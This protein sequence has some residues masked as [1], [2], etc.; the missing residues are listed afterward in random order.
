MGIHLNESVPVI[1][2]GKVME[3]LQEVMVY[4]H[5][6]RKDFEGELKKGDRIIIRGYG[7]PTVGTYTGA[8][9]SWETIDDTAIQLDITE[10]KYTAVKIDDVDKFQSDIEYMNRMSK[11]SAYKLA[12]LVDTTLAGLYGESSSAAVKTDATVDTA[13]IISDITAF[14]TAMAEANIPDSEMWCIVPFWAI[15]YLRMAGIRHADDLDDKAKN[16]FVGRVLGVDLYASNNVSGTKGSNEY[17]M[18][19]S[20]DAIALV[21]QIKE[22]DF[23]DK[24]EDTFGS[25]MRTLHVWGYKVVKP[26]ELFYADWT[27]NAETNI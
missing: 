6:A 12:Q 8:A 19:G 25:G 2:S 23:F 5:V 9:I 10:R 7:D 14:H 16:G 11:R 18:A 15:D 3:N 4:G 27:Y 17:P 22:S 24:F 13:T 20:Y 1:Y 26:K 21:E